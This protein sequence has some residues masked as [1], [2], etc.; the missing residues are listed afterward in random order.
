MSNKEFNESEADL[1]TAKSKLYYNLR[2]EINDKLKRIESMS[3]FCI[4][5]M[6]TVY[7]FVFKEEEVNCWLLLLPLILVVMVSY[8][9][10]N[11]RIYIC[12]ISAYIEAKGLEPTG[13]SWEKDNA[14]LMKSMKFKDFGWFYKISSS[15]CK[16]PDF[17]LMTIVCLTIFFLNFDYEGLAIWKLV[18][19]IAIAI[20]LLIIVANECLIAWNL[21][22]GT[23]AF[24][25]TAL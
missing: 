4:T 19:L 17:L 20:F 5:T 15:F 13:L 23:S 1:K 24:L 9:A 10:A 12:K 14:D 21:S 3:T 18:C 8:R 22:D 6:I 11:N 16:F 2:N 7:T 25:R